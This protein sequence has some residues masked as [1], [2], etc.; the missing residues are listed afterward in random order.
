[1]SPA[2]NTTRKVTIS[3]PADVLAYADAQA[4]RRNTSRSQ[5]IAQALADLKVAEQEA[6]AAEGYRFYA[7]E[8]RAFDEASADAVAEAWDDER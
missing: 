7:A 3:L 8:A 6:L 5:V 2:P 4:E 1:M